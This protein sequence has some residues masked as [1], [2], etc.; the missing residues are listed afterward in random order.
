MESM[1]FLV[2]VESDFSFRIT[3]GDYAISNLSYIVAVN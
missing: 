3:L 1:T 2:T